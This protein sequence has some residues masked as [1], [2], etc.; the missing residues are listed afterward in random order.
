MPAVKRGLKDMR[1]DTIDQKNKAVLTIAREFGPYLVTTGP[2]CS[3][4]VLS[5]SPLY[6]PGDERE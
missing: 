4:L 6:D 1:D 3:E 2:F 5:A